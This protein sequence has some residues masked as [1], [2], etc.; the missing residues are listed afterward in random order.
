MR[1]PKLLQR[2]R[3]RSRLR[4]KRLLKQPYLQPLLK[5]RLRL[6]LLRH[7]PRLR[8]SGRPSV[9]KLICLTVL[10]ARDIASLILQRTSRRILTDPRARVSFV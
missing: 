3:L 10:G 8:L 2:V 7:Q 4:Q 1:Q 6:K 9:K 5:S